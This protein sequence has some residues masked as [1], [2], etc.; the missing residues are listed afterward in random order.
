MVQT[1]Q[2]GIFSHRHV[3]FLPG[4]FD[5]IWSKKECD[6]DAVFSFEDDVEEVSSPARVVTTP[7][8]GA[9]SFFYPRAGVRCSETFPVLLRLEQRWGQLK[10]KKQ[11]FVFCTL[12]ILRKFVAE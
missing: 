6:M 4:N 5:R 8:P 11:K 1:F 7:F 3:L 9:P 2:G 10:R 12:A